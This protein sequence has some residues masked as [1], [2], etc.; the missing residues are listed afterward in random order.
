MALT[1]EQ[2]RA[3][4]RYITGW[5]VK[6]ILEDVDE[7]GGTWTDET[8]D[9]LEEEVGNFLDECATTLKRWVEDEHGKHLD[10][11]ESS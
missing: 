2:K 4:I 5:S 10:G 8:G 6:P 7:V 1:V 3:I 9:Q 11:R